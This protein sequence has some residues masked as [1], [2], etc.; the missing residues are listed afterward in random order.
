MGKDVLTPIEQQLESLGNPL[1]SKFMQAIREQTRVL[2]ATGLGYGTSAPQL[3][4]NSENGGRLLLPKESSSI[5]GVT[6]G[7]IRDISWMLGMDYKKCILI[8]GEHVTADGTT[9]GRKPSLIE[10]ELVVDDDWKRVRNF[11]DVTYNGKNIVFSQRVIDAQNETDDLFFVGEYDIA[12]DESPTGIAAHFSNGKVARIVNG[13][14]VTQKI[15]NNIDELQEEHP[16]Y[17]RP[18]DVA[19]TAKMY[20]DMAAPTGEPLSAEYILENPVI[21]I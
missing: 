5:Y 2:D 14:L 15:Y 7:F 12:K 18:I 6:L 10:F 20:L 19:A 21:F 8:F 3:R 4:P 16:R 13:E 17:A 9:L 11:G 1:E